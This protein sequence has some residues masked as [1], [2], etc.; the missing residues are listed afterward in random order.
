[1]KTEV[2]KTGTGVRVVIEGDIDLHVSPELRD[3]LSKALD[4]KPEL[5]VVDLALVP[6]VD[7]SAVA[8]IV[9]ALKRIRQ[10]SGALRV[11]NLQEAVRDTFD[12]AG[13]TRILGIT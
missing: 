13:L 3:V 7:S 10:W 2:K 1:M 9:G 8:T 12:I 11:E 4:A 5:L 6:F